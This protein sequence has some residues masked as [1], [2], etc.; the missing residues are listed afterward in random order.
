MDSDSEPLV[1]TAIAALPESLH[2]TSAYSHEWGRQAKSCRQQTA[3]GCPHSGSGVDINSRLQNIWWVQLGEDPVPR[4]C[5]EWLD[6]ERRRHPGTQ[7]AIWA[8]WH[9]FLGLV[10]HTP[11]EVAAVQYCIKVPGIEEPMRLDNGR[12]WRIAMYHLD[13][14]VRSNMRLQC[15]LRPPVVL[16]CTRQQ[17]DRCSERRWLNSVELEA[18]TPSS[19][20]TNTT[21]EGQP[22]K[23]A[24][25]GGLKSVEEMLGAPR[26]ERTAYAVDGESNVDEEGAAHRVVELAG[27]SY[28]NKDDESLWPLACDFFLLDPADIE[29]QMTLPGMQVALRNYQILDV[30]KTLRV[31]TLGQF[32]GTFNCSKPGLG[33]TLESLTTQAV[34]ALAFMS[35]D[36]CNNSPESHRPGGK[37][38]EKSCALGHP[39]GIRCFCT[40]GLTKSIYDMMT[41]AP[42]LV[43]A[44]PG[45]VG[46]WQDAWKD[47]MT[48]TVVRRDGRVASGQPLLVFCVVEGGRVLTRQDLGPVANVQPGDLMPRVTVRGEL[49]DPVTM[50][51]KF[52]DTYS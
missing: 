35:R 29:Q 45:I 22:H 15:A 17:A 7:W 31:L 4:S 2:A 8:Q 50:K 36:D 52:R 18:S 39:F 21:R 48:S 46:Q 11:D 20:S 44:P 33:K 49:A 3:S 30:Y 42:Q 27:S 12:Y 38:G 5:T 47:K 19:T 32:N 41:R 34:V 37:G 51:K 13:K 26:M 24:P 1:D 10:R 9:V 28:R 6:D 14:Q 25:Q 23:D 16:I 40:G 43:V